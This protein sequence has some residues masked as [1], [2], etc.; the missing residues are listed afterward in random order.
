MSLRDA[1]SRSQVGNLLR[2]E[3]IDCW[4]VVRKFTVYDD[5]EARK[6]ILVQKIEL[7]RRN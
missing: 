3:A 6:V 4:H 1:R 7:R 5:F 2:R